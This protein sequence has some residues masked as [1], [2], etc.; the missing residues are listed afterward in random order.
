MALSA[1]EVVPGRPSVLVAHQF[2]TASGEVPQRSDSEMASVGGLD[3]VDTGLFKAFDYVAL[4]HIHASQKMGPDT[5]RYAGSPLKYSFSEKN[6]K[7]SL[8]MVDIGVHSVNM[9]TLPL[10]PLHDMREISG[11]LE[12]LMS[13]E[14][15]AQQNREDYLRVVLA[16]EMEVPDAMGKLRHTY[17]NVMELVYEN[18]RSGQ[19]SAVKQA[20][21]IEKKTD[22]ELFSEFYREQ[23]GLPPDEEQRKLLEQLLQKEV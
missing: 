2:V 17:P 13:A 6:H 12:A 1:G 11:P 22:V 9:T 21:D 16:D 20:A 7:K 10:T 8:T 5:V 14:I 15:A 19:R 23:N 18:T 3:E 4:G